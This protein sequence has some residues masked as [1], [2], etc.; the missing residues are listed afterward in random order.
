M[1]FVDFEK[2]KIKKE[3][4]PKT[5]SCSVKINEKSFKVIN[6]ILNRTINSLAT[7]VESDYP[8]LFAFYIET[9]DEE[10]HE[11]LLTYANIIVPSLLRA[12]ETGKGYKRERRLGVPENLK[13]L[14]TTYSTLKRACNHE[15]KPHCLN[16]VLYMG[17]YR[18][19]FCDGVSIKYAEEHQ[20]E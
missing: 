15:I 13:A 17:D 7:T 8:S 16:I 18:Y 2:L 19:L 1:Y 3:Y 6:D 10:N 20:D 5:Y 4:N 11:D 12:L 14:N 9:A